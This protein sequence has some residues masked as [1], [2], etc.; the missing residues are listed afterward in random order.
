MALTLVNEERQKTASAVHKIMGSGEDVTKFTNRILS[1]DH[2]DLALLTINALPRG[3]PPNDFPEP[4]ALSQLIFIEMETIRLENAVS[5]EGQ[6]WTDLAGPAIV[7]RSPVAPPTPADKHRVHFRSTISPYPPCTRALSELT[8]ISLAD[9]RMETHHRGQAL[10]VTR[11]G[12]MSCG[13]TRILGTVIDAFGQVGYIELYHCDWTLEEDVIPRSAFAIKEPYLTLS[14]EERPVLRIDHPTDIVPLNLPDT[15][16]TASSD[17][18][19][20]EGELDERRL[21]PCDDSDS[22]KQCPD[23]IYLASAAFECQDPDPGQCL[24]SVHRELC[25]VNSGAEISPAEDEHDGERRTPRCH[26]FL[27]YAEVKLSR[28]YGNG[29]FRRQRLG[30]W[31][32]GASRKTNLFFTLRRAVMV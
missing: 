26:D 5:K 2:D 24:S 4:S 23:L 28:G 15:A 14:L 18:V 22:W 6:L 29:L 3:P 20:E 27:C 21:D 17:D 25:D 13:R 32:Y 31:R 7:Y 11:V 10:N 9:L 19:V 1:G 12:F 16:M 8:L 30:H